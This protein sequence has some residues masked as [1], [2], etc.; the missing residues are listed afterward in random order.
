M[1]RLDYLWSEARKADNALELLLAMRRRKE[2]A[3][4]D[5]PNITYYDGLCLKSEVYAWW[6]PI[7]ERL[8]DRRDKAR[9]LGRITARNQA[10]KL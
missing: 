10:N 4:D 7:Q 8:Y 9:R 2:R 5:N 3:I 6:Q 1:S